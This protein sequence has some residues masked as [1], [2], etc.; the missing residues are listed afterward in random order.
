MDYAQEAINFIQS[1]RL[2]L[3][4]YNVVV[5]PRSCLWILFDS[6]ASLHEHLFAF[7]LHVEIFMR[8]HTQ[9]SNGCWFELVE[10]KSIS[11]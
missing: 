5:L 7:Q 6:G 4:P 9:Q 8:P 11:E 2:H 3:M 1:E 10:A